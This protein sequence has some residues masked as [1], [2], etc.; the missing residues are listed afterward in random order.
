MTETTHDEATASPAHTDDGKTSDEIAVEVWDERDG[1]TTQDSTKAKVSDEKAEAEDGTTGAEPDGSDAPDPDPKAEEGD[2][3]PGAEDGTI[4]G[5]DADFWKKQADVHHAGFTRVSQELATLKK[6]AG[7]M[8]RTIEELRAAVAAYENTAT[9]YGVDDEAKAAV[10]EAVAAQK[11]KQ[12][13][14]AAEAQARAAA[15]AEARRKQGDMAINYLNQ[16]HGQDWTQIPADPH[17]ASWAATQ[18]PSLIQA[19][20][21]Y[22]AYAL[23][24]IIRDFRAY[25]AGLKRG[26]K[27]PEETTPPTPSKPTAG[28]P[29]GGERPG[30][31]ATPTSGKVTGEDIWDMTTEEFKKYKANEARK[32]AA[33]RGR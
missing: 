19:A 5:H 3:S 1:K 18:D 31:P 32:L 17:Y 6:S 9:E 16:R 23:D 27:P 11:A 10:N 30:K 26:A 25:K 28:P 12:E 4:D 14:A 24:I 13:A 20:A 7:E 21:Q 2:G 33:K 8:D 15:E 29:K 22:D